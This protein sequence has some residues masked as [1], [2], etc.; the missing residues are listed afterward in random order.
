[1]QC[2]MVTASITAP[3]SFQKDT[4]AQLPNTDNEVTESSESQM[5]DEQKARTEANRLKALEKAAA[6]RRQLQ[7]A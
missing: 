2:D 3:D 4:A 5:T 1:M 7:V 6:R